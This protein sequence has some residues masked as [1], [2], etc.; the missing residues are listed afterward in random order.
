MV[1][2]IDDEDEDEV[3]MW[4][5]VANASSE[6][7]ASIPESPPEN[8]EVDSI[9]DEH[10]NEDE[11]STSIAATRK[12][13]RGRPPAVNKATPVTAKVCFCCRFAISFY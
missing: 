1:I 10:E 6:D 9:A 3:S 8:G 2:D 13:R 5:L 12:R 4:E 11:L 7:V